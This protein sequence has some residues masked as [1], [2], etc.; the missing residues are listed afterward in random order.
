[1]GRVELTENSPS[2]RQYYPDQVQR[3]DGFTPSSQLGSPSSPIERCSRTA[4]KILQNLELDHKVQTRSASKK[5][6]GDEPCSPLRI[7]EQGLLSR[8]A[9]TKVVEP[10]GV[11]VVDS[12]HSSLVAVARSTPEAVVDRR[13]LV[14]AAGKGI[15][16]QGVGTGAS[17]AGGGKRRSLVEDNR[18]SLGVADR[19]S[20]EL[21]GRHNI[22]WVAAD[23]CIS[24]T[25]AGKGILSVVDNTQLC[26]QPVDM[27]T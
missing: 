23:T 10:L 2:L 9:G 17:G 24:A 27:E 3:V 15:A 11:V 19:G 22:L 6:G 16:P 5:I 4:I 7:S 14:V 1:M 25:A 20:V 21:E 13:A 18:R 26:F 8:K 12:K